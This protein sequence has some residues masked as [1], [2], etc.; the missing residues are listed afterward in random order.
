MMK[1][2]T[3][4]ATMSVNGTM[5]RGNQCKAHHC[6]C[7]SPSLWR[8]C[9]PRARRGSIER[10]EPAELLSSPLRTGLAQATDTRTRTG[11]TSRERRDRLASRVGSKAEDVRLRGAQE[12]RNRVERHGYL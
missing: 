5:A 1:T 6:H 3:M 7:T 10:V 9:L 8:T 12:A 11:V 4:K 2:T